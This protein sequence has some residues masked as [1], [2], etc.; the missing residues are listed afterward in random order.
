MNKVLVT[1]GCGYIGSHTIVE[2]L[3]NN[4]EVISIDNFSNS[5]PSVLDSI[6]DITNKRIINYRI[7]LRDINELKKVFQNNEIEFV[8]HFAAFKS[9]PESVTDPL[10]YYDNN[11]NGLINL[12]KFC[13][14]FNVKNSY[15]LLLVQYMVHQR[16][17][18]YL[19]IVKYHR[20]RLTQEQSIFVK[21]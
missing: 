3:E 4:Y 21:R 13:N 18:L 7:D 1:G 6:Y 2:L 17:Y 9:V 11:I 15:F 19:R 12:L 16:M 20:S 14:E 10:S 5:E 8:I